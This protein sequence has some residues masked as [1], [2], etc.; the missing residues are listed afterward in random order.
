MF[1]WLHHQ[2]VGRAGA[3]LMAGLVCIGNLG[4]RYRYPVGTRYL[5]CTVERRSSYFSV[6]T[7]ILSLTSDS[8]AGLENCLEKWS[9]SILRRQPQP[10]QGFSL[11]NGSLKLRYMD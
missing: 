6:N 10:G 9:P 2:I 8:A 4:Y 1:G 3:W 11:N 5:I 7:I